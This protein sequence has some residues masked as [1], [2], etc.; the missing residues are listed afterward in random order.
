MTTVVLGTSVYVD[1]CK[2]LHTKVQVL[3]HML[4]FHGKIA[5]HIAQGAL[6]KPVKRE[7]WR[8]YS[9]YS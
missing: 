9:N 5:K 1:A 8:G 3:L 4:P 6:S 2:V 7:K